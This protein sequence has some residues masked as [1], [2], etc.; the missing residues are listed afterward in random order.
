MENMINPILEH[1]I[2]VWTFI[3]LPIITIIINI[4]N[5]EEAVRGP[6]YSIRLLYFTRPIGPRSDSKMAK[7]CIVA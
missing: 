4:R 6:Q 2:V 7:G 5:T 1:T 3:R